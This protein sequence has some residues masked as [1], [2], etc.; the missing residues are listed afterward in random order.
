MGK[1]SASNI[2]LFN[3]KNPYFYRWNIWWL[4]LMVI[5]QRLFQFTLIMGICTLIMGI[6]T[7]PRNIHSQKFHIYIY[8]VCVFVCVCVC[9]RRLN[10]CIINYIVRNNPYFYRWNIW[11]LTLMV[12]L[13]HLFQFTLIMAICTLIMGIVTNSGNMHSQK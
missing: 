1:F 5:L 11:W 13:Q 4:T 8:I 3:E 2:A 12:L 10:Q 9:T 6:V 7:N